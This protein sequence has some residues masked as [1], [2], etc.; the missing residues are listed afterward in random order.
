MRSVEWDSAPA[1]LRFIEE[2]ERG[3]AMRL[4]VA[5]ARLS[6][7]W[8]PNQN[9]FV[10]VAGDYT[11]DDSSPKNGHRLIVGRT[12]GAPILSNVFDTRANLRREM[13]D[14]VEP[15]ARR[16]ATWDAARRLR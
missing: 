13:E 4:D 5:A 6:A 16:H 15:L 10:R 7:E 2:V 1:T 9:L 12:S 11:Q 3:D 14:H 8:T